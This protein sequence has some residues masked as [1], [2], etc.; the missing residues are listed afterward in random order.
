MGNI[1]S[2]QDVNKRIAN[3]EK[4]HLKTFIAYVDHMTPKSKNRNGI[5]KCDCGV[6]CVKTVWNVLSGLTRSCGCASRGPKSGVLKKAIDW[7]MVGAPDRASFDMMRSRWKGMK[8]RCSDHRD[9]AYPYYGGRG[10]S[11]CERWLESLQNFIFDMGWPLRNELS[12]DRI[13]NDGNYEPGN[14][15]WATAKEQANNRR[16]PKKHGAQK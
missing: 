10:I 8:K 9:R 16:P 4:T 14:C 1:L 15:R 11:V 2:V 5:F 7:R 6:E 12:L 13:N 3:L